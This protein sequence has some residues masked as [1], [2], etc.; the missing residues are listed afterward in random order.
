MVRDPGR[1]RTRVFGSTYQNPDLPGDQ[2]VR[3]YLKPVLGNRQAARRYQRMLTSPRAADLLA[4]EPD[5]RRLTVPTL[6]MWGTGDIFFPV[7]WAYWLRD[8]IPGVTNVVELADARL[9]FP[10]ERAD[11]L[12][13]ELR[14]HWAAH[15]PAPASS[16]PGMGAVPPAGLR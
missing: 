9:F 5:L 15:P 13:A 16:A 8:T 6:V 14:T 12:V 7:R 4:V 3:A 10:D 1:A 2:V 11:D